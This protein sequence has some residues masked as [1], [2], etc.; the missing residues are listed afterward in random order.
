M[1]VIA[2][3]KSTMLAGEALTQGGHQAGRS[4]RRTVPVLLDGGVPVAHVRAASC[5]AIAV[6]VARPAAALPQT[7]W[8]QRLQRAPQQGSL[9]SARRLAVGVNFR[10]MLHAP[11]STW[12]RHTLLG[13][14]TGSVEDLIGRL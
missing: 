10:P 11:L 4:D 7:Y 8:G 14:I 5:T 3:L 9:G 1:A 2:S 12:I 6:G 13:G